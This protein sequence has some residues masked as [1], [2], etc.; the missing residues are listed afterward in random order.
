MSKKPFAIWE[1][2]GTE[3]KLKLK[4]ATVGQLEEKLGRSL[5]A[6]FGTDGMPPLSV[7]LTIVHGAMKDWNSNIK[8][9]DVDNLFDQY[10]DEGGS[11]LEFFATIFMDIYKVSGFFTTKQIQDMETNQE[12][13]QE[14]L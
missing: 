14:A 3:Y 11:Q 2:N 1:V 8:R 10:L 9:S 5:I 6:V 4:T 12:K 13:I 7:M